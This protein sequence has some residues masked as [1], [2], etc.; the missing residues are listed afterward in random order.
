MTYQKKRS[1]SKGDAIIREDGD[2]VPL[3]S[4]SV[5]PT[6]WSHQLHN[7]VQVSGMKHGAP[8]QRSAICM[9]NYLFISECTLNSDSDDLALDG[10]C[11]GPP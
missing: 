1:T 5:I 8:T 7:P 3:R 6:S 10:T 9:A 11:T 4:A 2:S